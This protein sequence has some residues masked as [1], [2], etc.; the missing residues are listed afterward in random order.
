M[1][2]VGA[3]IEVM[4]AGLLYQIAKDVIGFATM[5]EADP[6]D[7][8]TID[9][10]ALVEMGVVAA[11]KQS[12][13]HWSNP[14][15]LFARTEAPSANHDVVWVTDHLRRQKRKVVQRSHDGKIDLIL[16][17]KKKQVDT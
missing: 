1:L 5:D 14:S 13:Y 8:G 9:L 4:V 10:S 12:E 2:A 16:I 3:Y 17:R 15:E 11:D 7:L 6:Y